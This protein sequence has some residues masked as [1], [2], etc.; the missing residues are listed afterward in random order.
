MPKN[1]VLPIRSRDEFAEAV[2]SLSTTD[3]V[4]LQ[5][6]AK[7]FAKNMP[8]DYQ[9][10]LQEAFRRAL[11]GG[12]NCP[13]D[14]NVVRFLA[15][16][17]RSIADG[18]LD[19]SQA[20]PR[21]VPIANHGEE[22]GAVDPPDLNLNAEQVMATEQEKMQME[23]GLLELFADDPISQIIVE[24]IMEGMEGEELRELT[25]LDATA[26]QSKRRLIRRRID[27]KFPEGWIL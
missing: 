10:L 23:L 19:K 7:Y 2:R 8:V 24:G 17:M 11:D 27:R 26:F 16:A 15:Q 1:K 14:I 6:A 12:R 4:R 18:E 9:D 22:D 13:A 5:K 21:L 25:E 3:W 20:R